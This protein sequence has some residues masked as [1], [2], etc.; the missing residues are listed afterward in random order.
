MMTFF[1]RD[2]LGGNCK[3][4]MLATLGFEVQNL[5]ETISTC[6]F[7]QNVAMIK[8]AAVV[9]EDIDPKLLI[10]RLKEENLRLKEELKLLKEDYSKIVKT[11]RPSKKL[12]KSEIQ[13]GISSTLK[14]NHTSRPI[15]F[16]HYNS[17]QHIIIMVFFYENMESSEKYL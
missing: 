16:K 10:K 15:S 2:S 11:S 8:N 14:K 13:P 7:A 17:L 3:T 1:L 9:N 6:Q 5:Q 4:C 12:G